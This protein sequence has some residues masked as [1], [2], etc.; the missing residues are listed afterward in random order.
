M[1]T[2]K[3]RGPFGRRSIALVAFVVAIAA[4][5]LVYAH[6]W[7]SLNVDANVNTGSVGIQWEGIESNDD[8]WPGDWDPYDTGGCPGHPGPDG[9]DGTDDDDECLFDWYGDS[10]GDPAGYGGEQYDKD[11]ARC[12]ASG[13]GQGIWIDIE[14]GYPSYHCTARAQIHNYGSVPIMALPANYEIRRGERECG[15][16]WEYDGDWYSN[17]VQYDIRHYEYDTDDWRPYVER[18]NGAYNPDGYDAGYDWLILWDDT[19]GVDYVDKDFDGALT[20][21]DEV[22]YGG[23]NFHGDHLDMEQYGD[24]WFGWGHYEEDEQGQV[25]FVEEITGQMPNFFGCG[26]QIDPD[27]WDDAWFNLH[28]EQAAEQNMSYS[29]SMNQEFVN[30]NEFEHSWCDG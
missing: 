7:T 26:T 2:R 4:A 15:W 29:F 18:G 13:D 17:M 3:M 28:V 19:D 27:Y 23:C 14:N 10:S 5:G 22:I 9:E 25:Y 21:G 1:S 11:V 16:W 6:W 20:A 12:Q 30:W 8:G 24:G